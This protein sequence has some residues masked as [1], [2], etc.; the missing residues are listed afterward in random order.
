MTY[1]HVSPREVRQMIREG[2]WHQRDTGGL[3]GG[4]V[5]TSFVCLPKEY[6]F[7]FFLFCQRNPAPQPILEVLG[8]G[9]TEPKMLAPGADIRTDAPGYRV[10]RNGEIVD[11]VPNL[12]D[13]WRDDLVTFFSGGSFSFEADLLALGVEL[14]HIQTA[15]KIGVY[16]TNIPCRPAGVFHGPLAV[17]MRPIPSR[18]VVPVVEITSRIPEAHGAPV[19]IG[20]PKAIGVDLDHPFS[21]GVTVVPDGTVPVFWACG[22]TQLVAAQMAKVDF[23]LSYVDGGVLVTDVPARSVSKLY[24][25]RV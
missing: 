3:A 10:W 11:I 22:D 15:E 18:S 16:V 2:R 4:Y 14:R 5:Q 13:H 20:D 12:L 25:P 21:G 23:M 7:D 19:W 24:W 6:A 17:S 9:E 8:P 1:A